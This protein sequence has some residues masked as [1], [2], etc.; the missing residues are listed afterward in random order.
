MKNYSLLL[1]GLVA[2]FCSASLGI[3]G[4]IIIVPALILL[5]DYDIKKAVGTS[6]ATIVP[7][8]L[9]GIATHSMIR[10]ENIILLVALFV[11]I[12]SVIGVYFGAKLANRISSKI[13]TKLFAVLLLFVGL[14]VTGIINIPVDPVTSNATY[15]LLII[16]GLI[17]GSASA[18]FGI[19]G[20]II[21]VPVFCLFFGLSIHEAI[22]TS[23][24]VIFP[25]T[26]AGAIFHKKYDNI[27]T[28]AIKYLI[29]TSLAGAVF[30][31]IF[32]NNMPSATLKL[33]FG[34]FMILASVRL[35]IQKK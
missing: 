2:G 23:L 34:I 30:G 26:L 16:L 14:K 7:A 24:T 27:S 20:G 4:G 9:V 19:G 28:G 6:L 11:L 13:L 18:L 29:P 22:A 1:L 15:P 21:M 8:A 10:H 32:A 3:G 12:G 5:V 17:A 35:I 33:I 31:A 25:T